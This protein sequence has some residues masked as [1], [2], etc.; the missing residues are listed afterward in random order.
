MGLLVTEPILS[1]LPQGKYHSAA[2]T[3]HLL[4]EMSL[5]IF[6]QGLISPLLLPIRSR[7]I[8]PVYIIIY[9]T[10]TASIQHKIASLSHRDPEQDLKRMDL[11]YATTGII[12][13]IVLA[14]V[15]S[16]SVVFW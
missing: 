6:G 13:A 2:P 12:R 11:K 14:C 15:G 7:I 3:L 9:C 16:V 4:N 10:T 1:L 8:T 5:S